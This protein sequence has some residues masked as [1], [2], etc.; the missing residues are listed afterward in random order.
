MART[1]EE[2]KADTRGRLLRAAAGLFAGRGYD[3]VSV[4]AVAD[5]ADRTS[6][7]VYAHFGGKHGLL[8]ALLNEWSGQAADVIGASLQ[9]AGDLPGRLQALWRTFAERDEGN[10]PWMLLEHELWLRGARDPAVTGLAAARYRHS[11]RGMSRSFARWANEAGVQGPL[12]P[13]QL[14]VCVLGLMLG[15]EMQ[16]RLEPT[17]VPDRTAE[18]GLAALFGLNSPPFSTEPQGDVHANRAV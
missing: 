4:D 10:S 3:A 6:G 17:A 9:A 13:D 5:E 15:L 11:R 8:V 2:R 16:R 7:S 14:A 12:D 1:Q 18:A